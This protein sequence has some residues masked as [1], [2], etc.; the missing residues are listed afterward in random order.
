[1]ART[2]ERTRKYL[3]LGAMSGVLGL[4]VFDETVVGVALPTIQAD[5]AMSQ[6]ESHWVVNAYLLTFTCFVALAGRLGDMFGR[7]HVFL[8]GIAIFGLASLAAGIVQNGAG[9]IGARAV[10]GVGA[11][12]VF[13]AAFAIVTSLFTAEERG[14]AFG[15][16]T[17]VGGVFMAMGPLV[18]G[19]FVQTLS[20]RWIFLINLPVVVAI[21]AVVATAWIAS[22]SDR[23]PAQSE[24]EKF[25]LP[26]LATLLLGVTALTVALMQGSDW[27]WDNRV[28][29]TLLVVG[30]AGTA[31]FV[32]VEVNSRQPL[33]DIGL[34]RIPAFAGG[35]TVFFMFQFDKIIVFI[36]V[37]LYLQQQLNLSPIEAGLPLVIAILPTLVTSL[38]AGRS[39]DRFGSRR[40]TAAGLLLNG[41]ALMLLGAAAAIE[42][43]A[44]VVGALIVWGTVLPFASVVPRRSLMSAVPQSHQGQASG[45]NLTVQMMGGTI[46]MAICTIVFTA[47]GRYSLVFWLTGVLVLAA[48]AAAWKTFDRERPGSAAT[49]AIPGN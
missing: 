7:H 12:I 3:I 33:I 40:P 5:L 27:G 17:T 21:G 29:V 28:I 15:V 35:V 14:M 38:V 39:A 25:D 48:V 45:V 31:A 44:M 26:G 22:D 13:P 18:G 46:G 37:P 16:Q 47:T 2:G 42:S 6:V 20:W 43:Y 49:S 23:Q 9:L 10:Q 8:F 24:K 4:V 32:F 34:F 1:M 19:V 41:S 30:V 36:F 11:A